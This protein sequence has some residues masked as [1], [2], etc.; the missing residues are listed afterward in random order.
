MVW[1]DHEQ[2]DKATAA[3]QEFQ[4]KLDLYDDPQFRQVLVAMFAEINLGV[5]SQNGVVQLPTS[6][7]SR[8]NGEKGSQTHSRT[9]RR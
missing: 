5:E 2:E 4:E 7:K 1:L 8:K 3:L 9:V 6:T